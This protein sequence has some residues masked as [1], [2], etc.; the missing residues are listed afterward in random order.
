MAGKQKH[1]PLGKEL[2]AG[3][4]EAVAYARGEIEL[5]THVGK[6]ST[7]DIAAIRKRLGLSQ[8]RVAL[9]FGISPA[10]LRDWEQGRRHPEGPAKVL[11]RVIDKEPEAVLRALHEH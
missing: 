8:A 1:S 11:L 4:K 9:Y 3:M 2:I 7:A 6:V 5:P 10:T